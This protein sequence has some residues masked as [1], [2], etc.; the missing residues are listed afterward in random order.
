M[1]ALIVIPARYGSQRFPGKP[2]ATIC[3]QSMLSRVAAIA[4]QASRDVE[5]MGISCDLVIATEDDRIAE[6]ARSHDLPVVV[7]PEDC[8]TGTDRTW[9]AYQ[10]LAINYD[11]V[12]NLQGD[13][14][15][16]PV[17]FLSSILLAF[18][19]KNVQV[20]T[21]VIQLSWF[22]LDSLRRNKQSTPFSGTTAVLNGD[23][24]G[25]SHAIWFSKQVLPAI[26]NESVLREQSELSPVFRHIGLYGYTPETLKQFVSLPVGHYESIEGLEQLRLLENGFRIRTVKVEHRGIPCFTGVDSPEDIA[27]VEAILQ[28][29]T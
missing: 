27:R 16:T 2:L 17:H 3:G 23:L 4:K 20:A 21:P 19:E 28:A 29:A 8:Q 24:N 14:P 12:L 13:A 18:K 22:E 5:E 10:K 11:V 25:N 26:R 7:T 9:S 1:K 6:H 15:L